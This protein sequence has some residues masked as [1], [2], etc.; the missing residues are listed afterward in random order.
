MSTDLK[1]TIQAY[2]NNTKWVIL[3]TV[4]EDGSPVL[5]VM[6][7]FVLDGVNVY[8]S[9]PKAT[10]K[11]RHI[12]KNNHVSFYFQ[13]EGQELATFKNVALIGL[14]S[15]VIDLVEYNRAVQ[16]LSAKSS[17]FR[18]KAEKGQLADSSIYRI[19]SK[20]FKYLD[21]SKGVGKVGI[22][23]WVL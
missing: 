2:I 12:G 3:A 10:D 20:E 9:T 8:F 15:E 14:A 21:R 4:R 13:H 5:R 19:D 6:G 16:L 1:T 11:V 18:E 23:E 22:E 7:S 17:R